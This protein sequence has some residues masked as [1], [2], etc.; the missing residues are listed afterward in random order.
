[1]KPSLSRSCTRDYHHPLGGERT[2][3]HPDSPR[4]ARKITESVAAETAQRVEG[5]D[6]AKLEMEKGKLDLF[7]ELKTME[8]A[9]RTGERQRDDGRSSPPP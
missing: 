6:E 7:Y 3:R 2:E 5:E 9:G 8:R 1:M 4:K